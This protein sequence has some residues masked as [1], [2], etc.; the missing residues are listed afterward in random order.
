VTT[1]GAIFAASTTS[2]NETERRLRSK[3]HNRAD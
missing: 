3:E 2:I 1:T